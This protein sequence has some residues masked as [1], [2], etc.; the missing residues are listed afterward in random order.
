MLRWLV[1]I[2]GKGLDTYIGWPVLGSFQS[3]AVG[4]V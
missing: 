2:D 3:G 4:L 1:W